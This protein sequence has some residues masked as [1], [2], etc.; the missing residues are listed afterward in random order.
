MHSSCCRCAVQLDSEIDTFYE[1]DGVLWLTFCSR[2]FRR[3]VYEYRINKIGPMS[4]ATSLPIEERNGFIWMTKVEL[5]GTN[6]KN[7]EIEIVL[8]HVKI[9]EHALCC[10]NKHNCARKCIQMKNTLLH[11]Q[12][13]VEETYECSACE[14]I[15]LLIAVHTQRCCE[16]NCTVPSCNFIR[17][18][19]LTESFING[20]NLSLN[21][22]EMCSKF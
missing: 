16:E 7:D 6:P 3:V 10:G 21:P 12:G 11:W 1:C 4:I 2:C 9:L 17:M 19:N 5:Y 18:N 20:N 14:Q 13:C 22:A 15:M 8:Q